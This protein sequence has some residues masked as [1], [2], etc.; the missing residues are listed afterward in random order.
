VHYWR[1]FELVRTGDMRGAR[2]AMRRAR[3]EWD[4]VHRSPDIAIA[5]ACIVS[6]LVAC[7]TAPAPALALCALTIV[8]SLL[9]AMQLRLFNGPITLAVAMLGPPVSAA[10]AAW[11]LRGGA[12]VVHGI[13]GAIALG[14]TALLAG[15]LTVETGSLL[16][17]EHR[18]RR[19]DERH[20]ERIATGFRCGRP[21]QSTRYCRGR[22]DPNLPLET[23]RG[24]CVLPPSWHRG[25]ACADGN[26]EPSKDGC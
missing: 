16:R 2:A 21:F 15:P 13:V 12:S 6:S 14:A 8:A 10:A 9:A 4:L 17:S 25:P 26:A 19:W 18:Q 23:A 22:R 7:A 5:W 20:L 24:M 1:A 3:S 11:F